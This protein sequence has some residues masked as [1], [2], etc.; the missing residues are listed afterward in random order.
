MA[1]GNTTG[2][3]INFKNN[4]TKLTCTSTDLDANA[5][6]AAIYCV[7]AGVVNFDHA[8][9]VYAS[10]THNKVFGI[11]MTGNK[12]LFHAKDRVSIETVGGNMQTGNNGILIQ[13]TAVPCLKG[14]CLSK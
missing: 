12:S 7:A 2:S 4:Y 6:H 10:A 14:L 13:K 5:N 11:Y 8:V 9:D 1:N 3:T